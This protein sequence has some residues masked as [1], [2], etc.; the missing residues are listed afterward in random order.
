MWFHTLNADG[1][2]NYQGQIL[3]IDG[4]LVLA[5]LYEWIVGAPSCVKPLAK[6]VFYSD[7]C[8]L[9]STNED[10]NDA[11]EHYAKRREFERAR[12]AR[13]QAHSES[14]PDDTAEST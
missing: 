5:Q 8:R 12:G 7:A 4:D 9:Y 2:I 3:G 10:M 1:E 6:A 14:E 11:Y 13:S